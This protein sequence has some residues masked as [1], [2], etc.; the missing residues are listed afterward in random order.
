LTPNETNVAGVEQEVTGEATE[1]TASV[2]VDLTTIIPD[3]RPEMHRIMIDQD[4]LH[5]RDE[6]NAAFKAQMFNEAE[7]LYTSALKAG[8][9]SLVKPGIETQHGIALWT[10]Y[11]NRSIARLKLGKADLALKDAIMSHTSAPS[12]VVKPLLRCIQVL[13][14]LGCRSEALAALEAAKGTFTT[15]EDLD[16]LRKVKRQMESIKTLRVGQN[17]QY[18]TIEAAV[19]AAEP[20]DEV[21]V[22]AG[23]YREPLFLAKPVTIRSVAQGPDEL[24]PIDRVGG[25]WA[26]VRC[27]WAPTICVNVRGDCKETVQLIDLRIICDAPLE[28][29]FHAVSVGDGSICV[30]R[31]CRVSSSSGPA[32]TVM[33][34][35]RIMAE[36][37]AVYDSS[38]GGILGCDNGALAL[39]HVQICYNA[40]SG[41]EL[42]T[43][44]SATMEA[45]NIFANGRQ[46]IAVW[47]KGGELEARGC[48][49]HSHKA[50]S[51][52]TVMEKGSSIAVFRDCEMYSNDIAGVAVQSKGS[53]RIVNCKIRH[54]GEGVLIQSSACAVVKNCEVF[55]NTA[56]GIF[57]GYDHSG[58]ATIVDNTVHQNQFKGIFLGTGR[59]KGVYVTG[60]KEHGNLGLPP[61]LKKS[62][63][64]RQVASVDL[65]KWAKKMKKREAPLSFSTG[66]S[67][68][69]TIFEDTFDEYN[70]RMF[71]DVADAVLGCAF[72]HKEPEEG[73]RFEKCSKC[74]ALCYCSKDCQ[75]NHWRAG[76]KVVCSPRPAKYPAF[77]DRS[78]SV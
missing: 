17:Q 14:A 11:S 34:G 16:L 72:C 36:N 24:T 28:R 78:E 26:E 60:N 53:A 23:V 74:Q 64:E 2:N 39:R 42:R 25:N 76:H 4:A 50:E 5:Y 27:D 54:N 58:T 49:V 35:A 59:C 32:V 8:K 61:L 15:S 63:T 46:G 62:F 47:N 21:L 40:A 77:I 29:S 43:G 73:V 22:E 65:R 70:S 57:I 18:K 41:L 9:K 44:A 31:N 67:A 19:F 13:D 33:T 51:G 68:P 1:A 20:G 3:R 10:L 52:I 66:G 45:C 75:I 56:N 69:E 55:G 71:H 30:L 6:G 38:Q 7:R 12:D 48:E 37:C